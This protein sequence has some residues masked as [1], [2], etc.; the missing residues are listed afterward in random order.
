MEKN[1]KAIRTG[2]V[3][4][5]I[6]SKIVIMGVFSILVA[7]GIGI[8]GINSLNRNSSNSEIESIVN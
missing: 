2:N 7:V 3:L 5:T 8:L 6:K 4:Q 1:Q